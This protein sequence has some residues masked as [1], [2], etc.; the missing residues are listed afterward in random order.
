MKEIIAHCGTPIKVDDDDYPLLSRYNRDRQGEVRIAEPPAPA[1]EQPV[2]S[3]DESGGQ[4]LQRLGMDG[5]L[6]AEEMH[7]RFP[8]VAEDDLLGWCCN[9]IMAGYDEAERR[10]NK[11]ESVE[12]SEVRLLANAA[13]GILPDEMT[14]TPEEVRQDAILIA[15]TARKYLI[16]SNHIEEGRRG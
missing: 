6:W 13:L 8:S 11:R 2:D 9:M 14:C 7:K 4:L 12:L 15:K 5:K 10:A 1:T 16:M 3:S